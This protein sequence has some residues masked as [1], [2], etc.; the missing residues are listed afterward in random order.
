MCDARPHPDPRSEL[1]R[2]SPTRLVGLR[3]PK[4]AE[5]ET[6][7][8]LAGEGGRESNTTLLQVS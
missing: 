5:S 1:E 6:G 4:R 2:R 8:P 3:Q 7:A